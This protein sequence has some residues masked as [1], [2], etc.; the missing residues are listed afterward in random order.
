[1]KSRLCDH[2]KEWVCDEYDRVTVRLASMGP[3]TSWDDWDVGERY[4]RPEQRDLH[5]VETLLIMANQPAYNAAS[6]QGGCRAADLE[7]LYI[8]NTGHL[9]AI[10]PEASYLY[11][12]ENGEEK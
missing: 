7:G 8:M 5:A 2:D 12:Q 1:M 3:F 6:K 11:H 10:L 4:S 9:G